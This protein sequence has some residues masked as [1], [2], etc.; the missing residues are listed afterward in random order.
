MT[1]MGSFNK[2]VVAELLPDKIRDGLVKITRIC[3]EKLNGKNIK[4]Q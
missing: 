4:I 1:D 3:N 2:E